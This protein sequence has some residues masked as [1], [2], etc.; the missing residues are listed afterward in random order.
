V[1]VVKDRTDR[2]WTVMGWHPVAA[3]ETPMV[4]HSR[5]RESEVESAGQERSTSDE[6]SSNR[7]TGNTGYQID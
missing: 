2:R 7:K 6:T 5:N 1:S 4:D 3:H